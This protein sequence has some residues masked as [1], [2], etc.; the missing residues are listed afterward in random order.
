MKKY[1]VEEKV[2]KTIYI[3]GDIVEKIEKRARKLR[4]NFNSI[5]VEIL[6]NAVR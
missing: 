3:N 5:A 1:E 4:R 6:E 2:R